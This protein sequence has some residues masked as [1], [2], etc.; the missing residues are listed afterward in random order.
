MEINSVNTP[1]IS[2]SIP[3]H[4][5]EKFLKKNGAKYPAAIF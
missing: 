4:N 1:E 3:V 5:G 2:V